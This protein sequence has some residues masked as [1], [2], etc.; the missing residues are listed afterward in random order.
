[1]LRQRRDEAEDDVRAR[2]HLERDAA[3]DQL[4]DERGIVEAADAMTDPVGTERVDGAPDAGRAVLLTGV[5]PPRLSASAKA[6]QRSRNRRASSRPPLMK[7]VTMPPKRAICAFA[8]ACC[9]CDE[10]PG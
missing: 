10:S 2:E 8:T 4:G 6:S 5:G 9:G 3:L 1:V 7:N